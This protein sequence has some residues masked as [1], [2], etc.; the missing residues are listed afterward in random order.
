MSIVK[1]NTQSKRANS[2]NDHDKKKHKT[3]SASAIVYAYPFEN[4]SSGY[5]SLDAELNCLDI[6]TFER[7]FVQG[8]FT[9]W[10]PVKYDNEKPL[11]ERYVSRHL[12][13][14]GVISL[15]ISSAL[16]NLQV[17]NSLSL[18]SFDQFY[19]IRELHMIE[20]LATP[21]VVTA[22]DASSDIHFPSTQLAETLRDGIVVREESYQSLGIAKEE[23]I[24][25]ELP[26]EASDLKAII[27]S[28]LKQTIS[29]LASIAAQKGIEK[30]NISTS[31]GK[32]LTV[33]FED[34]L[35]QYLP[36][37][38]SEA[39]CSIG[40]ILIKELINELDF[41]KY[42]VDSGEIL[43]ENG[44]LFIQIKRNYSLPGLLTADESDFLVASDI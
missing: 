31:K 8:F 23:L 24:I 9:N 3:S 44:D 13:R 4:G 42:V 14:G 38:S 27:D 2:W 7:S 28:A 39:F 15:G 18:R 6:E 20:A 32:S 10:L 22:K 40:P 41:K 19:K 17:K 35:K 30:L 33:I 1:S 43:L 37:I 5:K 11:K 36:P 34:L 25:N 16:H 21:G 26:M 12:D 29:T